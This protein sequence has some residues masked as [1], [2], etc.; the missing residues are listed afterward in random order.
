MSRS[1]PPVLA[2]FHARRGGGGGAQRDDTKCAKCANPFS[3]LIGCLGALLLL[4]PTQPFLHSDW[5]LRC[6]V[7]AAPDSPGTRL[8]LGLRVVSLRQWASS[9]CLTN[10]FCLLRVFA[11]MV[12]V[13]TLAW[14]QGDIQDGQL[15]YTTFLARHY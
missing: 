11:G 8:F 10:H 3:I 14:R 7:V 6:V 4:L 15:G 9:W 13:V 5:L 2:S 12:W 1:L